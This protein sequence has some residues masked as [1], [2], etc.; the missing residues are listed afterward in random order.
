[1][2]RF[3]VVAALALAGSARAAGPYDDLIKYA[4]ANTNALV[5]ID[6]KGAHASALATS[7]KWNEK[8]EKSSR[9]W[10]GFV[11]TEGA[12]VV[13]CS[14]VNL[15]AMARTFQVGLVKVKSMPNFKELAAR[16]GGTTVDVAGQLVVLSPRDVYFVALPTL[17]LAAVHPADRQYTAR[18]L[19]ANK[20]GTLP[21]LAPYLR[22]AA[23]AASDSAVTIALDL[24]DA[25]DPAVLRFGLSVGP[26]MIRHKEVNLSALPVFLGGVKGLTFSAALNDRAA[27]TIAIEFADDPNRY[28]AVLKDLFLEQVEASGIAIEGLDKWEARSRRRP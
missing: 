6:V 18:W 11:P 2:S 3:A 19:K 14:E 15:T 9:G 4:P 5:L 24:E 10:L 17:T 12:R 8:L 23:D 13:I 27:G 26:V 7:E 25:V 21:P 16:E 28:K 1:M 20:S 22:K